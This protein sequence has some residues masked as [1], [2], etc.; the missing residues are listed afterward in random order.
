[1]KRNELFIIKQS[2]AYTNIYELMNEYG[3]MDERELADL[4]LKWCIARFE[5]E[6]FR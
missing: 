1:M 6:W 5:G 4:S 2:T 3:K